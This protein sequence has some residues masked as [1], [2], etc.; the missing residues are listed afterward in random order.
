[1]KKGCFIFAMLLLLS[2]SFAACSCSPR[3]EEPPPEEPMEIEEEPQEEE[4]PEVIGI[5]GSWIYLFT[6]EGDDETPFVIEEFAFA[7]PFLEISEEGHVFAM[8]YESVI[9]GV[10]EKRGPY[11][12]TFTDQVAI[13]EG[14]QWHPADALLG[15]S[16]VS[17][18]LRYSFTNEFTGEEVHHHFE[19]GELPL[20]QVPGPDLESDVAPE[21]PPGPGRGQGP[22][23]PI[24]G[25]WTN[26]GTAAE[27][28]SS[29]L[30]IREDLTFSILYDSGVLIEGRLIQTGEYEFIATEQLWNSLHGE[31]GEITMTEPL[32]DSYFRFDPTSGVLYDENA[33]GTWAIPYTRE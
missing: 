19:R 32:P 12:Y 29:Q 4:E 27:G 26:D 21:V 33:E 20:V 17:G 7:P 22:D 24:A 30:E 8:F 13:G 16:L 28:V 14:V 9:R 15:Y 23:L 10:L 2:L 18:I 3:E 11:A 1:M 6:T 5:A 25:I 31:T